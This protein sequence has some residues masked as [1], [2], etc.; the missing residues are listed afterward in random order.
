VAGAVLAGGA[1]RRMG[2]TKALIDVAGVP[3]ASRVG[4]ALTAAGCRPVVVYGGDPVELESLDLPVIPDRYPGAGPLGGV[5]GALEYFADEPSVTHVAVVACD[6]PAIE[7]PTLVPLIERALDD[8]A[9]DVVVA[10][11]D[12]LEPACAIWS[13]TSLAPVRSRFAAGE[14]ALHSTIGALSSSEID[15]PPSSL[16]NINTPDD[17]GR[18]P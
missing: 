6:L 7:G 2:R 4:R 10:R 17:L 12:R 15:V 16:V 13:M 1:S 3:M 8:P 18:Y 11:T 9:L 14:R 5:L